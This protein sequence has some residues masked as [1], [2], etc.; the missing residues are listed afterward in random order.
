MAAKKSENVPKNMAAKYAEITA[1]TDDFCQRHLNDE[2]AKMIR[3]AVAAMARKRPSPLVK[4]RA[5]SWACGAA[6]AIGMT[7]FVFDKSQQPTITA[8]AM[9]QAFGL[10][11]S[12]GQAKSKQIRDAL[13]MSQFDGNWT[14]PSRMDDN[15]MVWMIQVDGLIVDA[16]HLPREIQEVAFEKGLIPY[17][18]DD[19]E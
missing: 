16:R 17:I 2:Y 7:N 18:P 15:P 4:G 9:Y 14:L 6:H 12:T 3:Y 10:A 8:K 11:E 5:N 1:L 19:K 13:K